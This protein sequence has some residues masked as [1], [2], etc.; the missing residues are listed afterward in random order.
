MNAV[1]MLRK[2]HREDGV[3]RLF[4]GLA[5]RVFWISIGGFVFFGSY[6]T[7]KGAIHSALF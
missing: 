2:I 3:G 5:P 1:T 7:A 6:E 4:S